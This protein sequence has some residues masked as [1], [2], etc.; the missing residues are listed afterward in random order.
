MFQ[1]AVAARLMAG[2]Q[3]AAL[4]P[5]PGAQGA[6]RAA[7][8]AELAAPASWTSASPPEPPGAASA[9][10]AGVSCP[11]A[12]NC[13][14]VGHAALPAGQAPLV[15]ELVAGSWQQATSAAVPGAAA[16]LTSVSCAGQ[17][18][19]M[20]V[21]YTKAPGSLGPQPLAEVEV[22]SSWSLSPVPALGSAGELSGV[23][24]SSTTSCVAVGWYS[25]GPS[26]HETLVETWSASGWATAPSADPGSADSELTSVACGTDLGCTAVGWYKGA[27]GPRHALV[28]QLGGGVWQ[29]VPVRAA[30]GSDNVL[31]GVS[32]P[33]SGTCV[34]VG[35]Y[36][37]GHAEQA[38]VDTPGPAGWEPVAGG[39]SA[40]VGNNELSSVSCPAAGVCTAVGAASNGRVQQALVAG[41]TGGKWDALRV[42]TSQGGRALSSVDCAASR[43][44]SVG[45]QSLPQSS[46]QGPLAVAGAGRTWSATAPPAPQ[47][48]YDQLSSVSCTAGGQCSAVGSAV[49]A[50][51]LAVPLVETGTGS[52]WS[53]SVLAPPAVP[54][55]PAGAPA[56]LESVSCPA[57]GLCSAVGHYL[58]VDGRAAPLVEVQGS[59]GWANVAVPRL[60]S[61]VAMYLQAISCPA[62][63]YCTAVGYYTASSGSS[64]PVAFTTS[65]GAWSARPLPT[66]GGAAARLASVSCSAAGTCVAVGAFTSGAV[67]HALVEVLAGGAWSVAAQGSQGPPRGALSGV[68]CAGSGCLAVG[69]GPGPDGP[70]PLVEAPVKAQWSV[71]GAPSAGPTGGRLEAVSCLGP[72]SCAVAG[73]QPGRAGSPDQPLLSVLASGSWR[74]VPAYGGAGQSAR[75]LGVSCA[76]RLACTTVGWYNDGQAR[77]ALVASGAMVPPAPRRTKVVLASTVARAVVGGP[78]VLTATVVPA[79][80]GGTVSFL[81][82]GVALAACQAVLPGPGGRVTCTVAFPGPGPQLLQ[83][84]FSG[85]A[86]FLPSSS[87]VT[88]L[89]VNWPPQGYWLATRNGSVLAEGGAKALGA[90]GP[91]GAPVTGI[92]AAP[93]GTGYWVLNKMGGVYA[94]GTARFY[95]DLPDLHIKVD[96]AVA[97]AP[98]PDGGGYWLVGRDGGFFAFGDAR[99]YGSLPALH[100][101]VHDITAMAAA[102]D[103]AGYVLVGADGGVFTFGSAHY[104][105]P[106]AGGHSRAHDVRAVLEAPGGRGYLLVEADGGVYQFGRGARFY[107]SLPQR[108]LNVADIV[109]AAATPDGHGYWLAGA[110]GQ[111]YRFGDAAPEPATGA[112]TGVVAIA[113]T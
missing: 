44:Q 76:T 55:L 60:A 19:C 109:G 47:A 48:P 31:Q 80:T 18:H 46:V 14:A 54:G 17:G 88:G 16:G 9:G 103:G 102:P 66:P 3:V 79:P 68:S 69:S 96:D 27:T 83:A 45:S 26:R 98:T 90:P 73:Y 104:A 8:R 41:L 39:A 107:G 52:T 57:P 97:I 23:W 51:R 49:S 4:T 85:S 77:D 108:H 99:F 110:N 43:C 1:R 64:V 25:A 74:G 89:V 34:A 63:G 35:W 70:A 84:S 59:S 40:S 93:G 11:S 32:C 21:G 33:T 101:H 81:D 72:A 12:G 95:G 71:M 61:S 62:P 100:R 30:G 111:V 91:G 22:G 65:G 106:L 28:E 6:A 67:S 2:A 15:E 75:L 58:G 113:G 82:N 92:A 20:A 13:T 29:A 10:L 86:G 7:V 36:F 78:V 42:V 50:G 5:V 105:G 94:Y 112:A 38:L 37:N 87:P 24:C 53:A 56:Y